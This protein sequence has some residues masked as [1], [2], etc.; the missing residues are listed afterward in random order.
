MKS[1]TIA[2]LNIELE[3]TKAQLEDMAIGVDQL[4]INSEMRDFEDAMRLAPMREG[5]MSKAPD[6]V[7]TS[8]PS[9]LQAATPVVAPVPKKTPTSR[10]TDI[11]VDASVGHDITKPKVSTNVKPGKQ[12]G[13]GSSRYATQDEKD[14]S[15]NPYAVARPKAAQHHMQPP[16]NA[17]EV[18]GGDPTAVQKS[19]PI[20][21]PTIPQKSIAVDDPVV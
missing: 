12:S 3:D 16:K 9:G 19:T 2:E 17:G 1:V 20:E 13:T 6:D 14:V 11:P 4:R 7:A 8:S 21:K 10:E 15:I 18:D 5:E